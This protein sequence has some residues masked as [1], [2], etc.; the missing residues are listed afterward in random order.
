MHCFNLA[1]R[2]HG[3]AFKPARH[4]V[5]AVTLLAVALLNLTA[6]GGG[7]AAASSSGEPR[8]SL[9][10]GTTTGTGTSADASVSSANTVT[11]GGTTLAVLAA[12]ALPTQRDAMRLADQA[13]F[14]ASEALIA[15]IQS[16]GAASW[17]AAQQALPASRYT[18]GGGADVHQNLSTTPYCDL[19]AHAGPNC[20]RDNLSTLPLLWDFYRNA[21]SQP[22][23]LRQR[24]AYALQQGLVV[25]GTEVDG[26]YGFRAYH[27]TLLDNAFGNYRQ[28]LKNVALSPV[29]GE[30]LNNV[31]NHK[32]APNEN[33]ARELLQL[34]AI[35]PCELNVDGSLKTGRCSATYSNDTVRAYA[36]ALTGWT[37]PIGGAASGGCWPAGANCR[38]FSGNMV[39]LPG[40]HDTA[41]RSLLSGVTLPAGHSAD[42]A[43]EGVL[44]SLLTHPNAAPFVGR[45]LIQQLV[46]SNPQPAYVARVAA[47]FSSGLFKADTRSFGTGVRGD[48]A[49]TV[50]AVL[51][52]PDARSATV[53]RS[54]GK[55]REP[56]LL[57]TGVLRALNGHTDGDA[58][59]WWWGG[60][61]R[62]HLFR[63]PS[64]FNFYSPD[65]PV[66]G[67]ALVGPAFGI[68]DSST[69]L[70]RLNYLVYLLDVRGSQPDPAVPHATG[71]QVDLTAFLADAADAA[72]LVD[73]ISLIATGGALPSAARDAV[74]KGVSVWTAANDP[75]DWR[76]RRVRTAAFLVFG[77]PNYQVQR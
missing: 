70:Q 2:P 67:T 28:V 33:F 11:P 23:Q 45:Q 29:M 21:L 13:S 68:L 34:F 10:T 30:Y 35:G 41:Q 49:A 19:P 64:V 17:I 61:L 53:A 62:Q 20:W 6:C 50:A 56:V 55:L 3:M 5:L 76:A 57:F 7:G 25:S 44:D 66:P 54:A 72:K 8:T 71:T 39:P 38:F 18:A 52:D 4:T 42:V 43:L 16:Q 59:A 26:S 24:V 58:L 48:L 46:M 12:A 69:A 32:A 65:Q 47:A 15:E 63:P 51:L 75:A 77:S 22:D 31:N 9:G 27:N 14:G 40:F 74:V 36:Y 37:Y 1:N 73:R 60:N